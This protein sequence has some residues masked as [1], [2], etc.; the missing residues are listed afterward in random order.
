MDLPYLTKVLAHVNLDSSG[1]D[2]LS[3]LILVIPT[4][5][6]EILDKVKDKLANTK[7]YDFPGDN[8]E[9]YYDN[10]LGILQ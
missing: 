4:S 8:F 9:F 7:L 6:F 5:N 10:Q 1:P 3:A 2:I